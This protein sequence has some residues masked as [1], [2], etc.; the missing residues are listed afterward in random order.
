MNLPN[1]LFWDI[2]PNSLDYTRNARYIIQRVIQKGSVKDWIVIKEFYGLDFIKQEILLMRDL[3]AKTLNFF[4][5]YFGINKNEFRC[6]T[7]QQSIPGHFN[8]EY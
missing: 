2:D 1:Y 8:S 3:D 6:Y 7:I 4:S 5:V